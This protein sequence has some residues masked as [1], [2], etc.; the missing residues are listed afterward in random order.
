[1]KAFIATLALL[2]IAAIGYGFLTGSERGQ[3][4]LLERGAGRAVLQWP[5]IDGLQVMVCGSSSPL[6][7]PGRAQACVLVK[8][9]DRVLLV[10]AGSGSAGPLQRFQAPLERLEGVLLTHFHSDH[11]GGLGD[12]NLASWVAG[13]ERPLIVRG[14]RGVDGVVAGFNQAYALDNGYR[15]AHHGADL[16]PP[17]LAVMRARTI[18]SGEVLRGEGLVVRAIPVDHRPVRPSFAYRFDYRGRSVVISGDTVTTRALE[19]AIRDA[20]LLVHDALSLKLV[21]T[22]ADSLHHGGR[23]RQAQILRDVLDY[24]AHTADVVA[25]AE[26]ARVAKVAFYHLV[27]PPG[28]TLLEHVFMRGIPEAVV[29]TRDGMRFDLPAGTESIDV[30][31]G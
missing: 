17:D 7:D 4:W 21:S 19:A 15:V 12:V 31:G 30:V 2:G 1:M 14:P 29:M 18:T 25:M 8:A 3:D 16:L 13:R 27:P 20:D 6:P 5:E 9:G 22:F 23:T 11:N 10:D 24:H 26:R 28:N